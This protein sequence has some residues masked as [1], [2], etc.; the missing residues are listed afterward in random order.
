M[1]YILF[2]R[3]KNQSEYDLLYVST[4]KKNSLAKFAAY[5]ALSDSEYEIFGVC[6][7]VYELREY[8]NDYEAADCVKYNVIDKTE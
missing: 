6:D 4:N 1:I 3:E 5:K 8:P 2:S 7:L